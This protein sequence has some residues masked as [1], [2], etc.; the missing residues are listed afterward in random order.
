MTR[1]ILRSARA[2]AVRMHGT[3]RL[4]RDWWLFSEVRR[5]RSDSQGSVNLRLLNPGRDRV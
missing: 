4:W 2:D 5:F 3:G 1:T